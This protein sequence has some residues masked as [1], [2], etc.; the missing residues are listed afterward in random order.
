MRK[1]A[2]AVLLVAF[3]L[4]LAVNA[5]A[6]MATN[7]DLNDNGRGFTT[8]YCPEGTRVAGMAYFDLKNDSADAV[9]AICEYT[10]GPRKGDVYIPKD[11]DWPSTGLREIQRHKCDLSRER[12]YG[13]RYKDRDA[14]LSRDA[15]DGL[16]VGCKD[17][18]T[19]RIRWTANYDTIG[20][21]E[22]ETLIVGKGKV[23]GVA[24][25]DGGCGGEK[26]DCVD[27]ATFITK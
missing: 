17:K 2:V 22:W 15:M 13:V 9:S 4:M 26:S 14:T 12:I 16:S 27:G 10:K 3:C 24:Y 5:Q 21:R 11:G 7:K 8:H 18:R 25:K 6:G 19:G 1:Y 20:G 23:I